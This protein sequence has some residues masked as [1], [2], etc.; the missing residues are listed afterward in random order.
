[1]DELTHLAVGHFEITTTLHCSAQ[2]RKGALPT[3]CF[4]RGPNKVKD[5]VAQTHDIFP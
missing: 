2:T 3:G 1:M 4:S 5:R